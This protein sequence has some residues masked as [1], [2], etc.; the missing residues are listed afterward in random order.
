MSKASKTLFKRITAVKNSLENAE[1]SFLD[2]KEL[3]GEL[4]LM[5]A[6][7]ELKNLRRK[8]DVP[9]NWNRQLLAVLFSFLVAFSGL[10]G[11][12]YARNHRQVQPS[13]AAVERTLRSEPKEEAVPAKVSAD[14]SE[15]RH[16]KAVQEEKQVL[17]S[18]DFGIS[19]E[20]V[21]RLVRSA[22]VELRNPK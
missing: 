21:R 6:E 11:W 13:V 8:D 18:N 22:R 14:V 16:S 2:N 5:L 12:L 9:W 3:R 1:K 19:R 20:E 10:G 7:A 4:D 15:V 17:S